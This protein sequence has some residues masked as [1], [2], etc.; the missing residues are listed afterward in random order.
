MLSGHRDIT[1]LIEVDE[2]LN[3]AAMIASV[4]NNGADRFW[5]SLH[6]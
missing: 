3:L 5:F 1:N 2:R 6:P 4:G